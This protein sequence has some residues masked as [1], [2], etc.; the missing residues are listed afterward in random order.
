MS[1][2]FNISYAAHTSTCTFLLDSEGVCR[3]IV[4]LPSSKQ[5]VPSKGRG[6]AR[7]AA[8]CIGAQYVAS[9]DPSVSGLLAEMP[10]VG[11]AMLF[12]RTDERGRVSLVRTGIVTRFER[13]RSEDP[14]VKSAPSTSVQTSAPVIPPSASTPRQSRTPSPQAPALDRTQPIQALNLVALHATT[15]PADQLGDDDVTLDRTAEYESRPTEGSVRTTWP[16]PGMDA[17]PTLRQPPPMFLTAD[18]ESRGTHARG[19][20]PRVGRPRANRIDLP[21]GSP[22]PAYP[23]LGKVAAGHRRGER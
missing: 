20:V 1:E 10:R 14:F 2:P 5:K 6:N 3:R 21:S 13:H 23:S 12:A 4:M 16:S 17:A 9:L 19:V 22:S 11:G 8:R 7:S 18:K 15:A